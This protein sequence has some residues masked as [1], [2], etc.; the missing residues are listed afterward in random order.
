MP[1]LIT[2]LIILIIILIVKRSFSSFIYAVVIIDMFLRIITFIKINLLS[3][4]LYTA[5]NNYVPA[6]L[7]SLISS[8]AGGIIETFLIWCIVII[9]VI[10]EFYTIRIFFKKR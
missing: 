5:I 2:I 1:A 10:F 8:Y 4:A 7:S 3:G 9:Y 6:S